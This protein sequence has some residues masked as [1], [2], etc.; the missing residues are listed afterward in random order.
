MVK[1]G[2]LYQILLLMNPLND[3]VCVV[4]ASKKEEKK[5]N[6]WLNEEGERGKWNVQLC[7]FL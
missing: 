1:S 6:G 4:Y 3:C 2:R 5:R 7:P